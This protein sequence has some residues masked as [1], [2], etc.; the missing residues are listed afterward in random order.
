MDPIDSGQGPEKSS[1]QCCNLSPS[2][3]GRQRKINPKYSDYEIDAVFGGTD[4]QKRRRK[5]PVAAREAASKKTPA[6]RGQAKNATQQTEDGEKVAADEIPQESDGKTLQETPKNAV[7]A[8][9]TPTKKTRARKTPTKKTRAKRT[10][11]KKTP[12][13]DGGLATGEGGIVDTV[14]QENGTPKPKRKYVRKLPAPEPLPEPPRQEAQGE[15]EE[16]TTPSGR[17]RRG[18]AKAALKYLHIFAKEALSHP[19]DE[20]GSQ[21]EDNDD[22]TRKDSVKERKSLKGRKGRKRKRPDSDTD[23]AEDEDFVP[24]V[25]E[26][27]EVEEEE[28]EEEEEAEDSDSDSGAGGR[29]PATFYVNRP[30][31][32]SKIKTP[33][34]LFTSTMN[35]VWESTD[36]TKKFRE[37]HYSSWVFPEWVPSSSH[38]HPVPQSDVEKYLPQELQSAAF[39]VSREG[40]SKEETPLQRLSRFT[41]VPSHPDRWDMLLYAGGPVWAME[42]C[43]TPDGAP[44][45]QYIALA[46]HRG[47]DDQHYVNKMYSGSGVIQLWDLGTLEYN[48]RPDSQPALA[49]G[50]AQDKGFIWQLKWCP[51]GGWE[52]PSCGRK[53]PFLPRLGLLAVA[54]STGVVT[55]Y[56][57]PHPDAL[58]SNRRQANSGKAS[59]QL[60]IYQAQGVLTLKLGSFKAPRH[61]RSGQV[62]S[63]DWLPQKPHNIMAIG[64]YDGVVGLWDLSTKSSLL[65]V[66]EPGESLS[67]LPYRCLLAHDHA[68]RALAFCPASR[69]LLVTAGEDRYV[70]T[71]DLRRLHDPI[72]VQKRYLTN[73]IYWPLNAPGILLA[74]ENAYAP[75][76]SQ[77]VHYFDHNMRAIFTIPRTGT[78]WSLSYT[79]WMNSVVTAD[80]FGEVIFSLLPQICFTPQYLKRTLE[81]RFPVY[82]TTL[83]AHDISEEENQ[84]MGGVEDGNAVEEKE[85]G[86]TED[87]ES[88]GGNENDNRNGGGGESGRKDKGP[89]LRFQTYKEAVKRYCLLHT[90]FNMRTF[91]GSEKQAVWK[92]MKDT[93]LKRKLNLDELPIAALHKVRFNPNMCCHTWVV[94]AGQTGLVRLN[95]LRTM[96]SSHAQKI[97][98]ENQAQF[99]ALYSPKEQKEANQTVT[100]EL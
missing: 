37:E 42:W 28:E 13:T 48:S 14:L 25:E 50:L 69:Y 58:H 75:Y 30:Q 32:G 46:C 7:R 88:E 65:R 43:P 44:A 31:A 4:G 90:D 97:I 18:A 2:S 3:K 57:L 59:E 70:K 82:I 63:M 55:I 29:S 93:E 34:G 6:K 67:L 74:Q 78:V 86:E 26:D 49:Y 27:E 1:E 54:T 62:L 47:M 99:N 76:A 20:S 61:Q 35:V 73:E 16:E 12:T 39:R 52:L 72:T 51:S 21:A 84:E 94:S 100:D 19:N 81:R 87:A 38:W 15:P 98:S 10:P 83:L 68:V 60:P 33:N 56:S 92:H 36:T 41:A 17:H 45:S 85:G 23:A 53:A 80:S 77:G 71:W 9:K 40:L 66:R 89:P 8:R 79:D 24:G 91:K 22:I 96:I 11:A 95:C 5:S 64:F